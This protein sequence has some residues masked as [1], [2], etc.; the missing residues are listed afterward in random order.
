MHFFRFTQQYLSISSVKFISNN[1]SLTTYHEESSFFNQNTNYH[2]YLYINLIE[3]VE[4]GK[5]TSHVFL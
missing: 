4:T 2:R 5:S 1:Y 3:F